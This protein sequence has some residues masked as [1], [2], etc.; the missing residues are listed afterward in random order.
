MNN[1]ENVFDMNNQIG[2]NS[3]EIIE[4]IKE[5]VVNNPELNNNPI[6]ENRPPK[7]K[8][9][10]WLIMII[11]II[12][13]S[14]VI[15]GYF[16][17]IKDKDNTGKC[18]KVPE[19][20]KCKEC[21]E[22]EKCPEI[23]DCEKQ[24]DMWLEQYYEEINIYSVTKN[25]FYFPPIYA[26]FPYEDGFVNNFF[27]EGVKLEE[28]SKNDLIAAASSML[29]NIPSCYCGYHAPITLNTINMALQAKFNYPNLEE[30]TLDDLKKYNK[31]VIA[32]F[33]FDGDNIYVSGDCGPDAGSSGFKVYLK[34]IEKQEL[35]GNNLYIYYRASYFV[36]QGPW[37]SEIK[38]YKA[39][40]KD[41]KEVIEELKKSA[42]ITWSKYPL[43]KSTYE[44]IDADLYFRS[45]EIIE[46]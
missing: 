18:P 42:D 40:D 9:N 22:C 2:E 25:N 21:P 1:E 26:Q 12:L 34:K 35:D 20:E 3:N 28:I 45:N 15:G 41:K 4:E 27:V 32:L 38:M 44:L 30:I 37:Q 11:V 33:T 10:L 24:E 19:C 8:K 16:V 46:K 23:K 29:T 14:G 43:Y 6:P 39:S 5:V 13:I 17:Y 7:K 36:S 31:D